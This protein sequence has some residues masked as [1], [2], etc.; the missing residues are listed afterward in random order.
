MIKEEHG[1]SLVETLVALAILLAVLVPAAMFLGVT[2]NNPL[3]REKITSFN[4]A[5]TAMEQSLIT[6]KEASFTAL[7]DS[8]WWVRTT[9]S[10]E[11]E[12]LYTIEVSVFKEDTLR[13]PHITLKTKRLWYDE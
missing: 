6:R 12:V 13:S 2:G 11:N 1:Y 7:K 3:A 4:L 10:S 9:V 8:T 5:K